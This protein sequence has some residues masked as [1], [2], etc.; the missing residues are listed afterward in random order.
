MPDILH[1]FFVKASPEKIFNTF[2]TSVGLNSWWSL[3]SDGKPVVHEI[4]RFYFCTE[5]DWREKL[6]G[7]KNYCE[8]GAVVPFEK[9]H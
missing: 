2:T 6:Q 5:Y 8:T 7:L 9:W 1:R 3:E 4:Y